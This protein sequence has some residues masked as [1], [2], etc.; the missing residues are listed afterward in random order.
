[1]ERSH[2]LFACTVIAD[3][4]GVIDSWEP[5]AEPLTAFLARNRG[6]AVR[7]EREPSREVPAVVARMAFAARIMP[8]ELMR[9]IVPAQSTKTDAAGPERVAHG[10]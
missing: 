8:P 4:D 9:D 6:A 3:K 10:A 5:L 7:V 1:M 2:L